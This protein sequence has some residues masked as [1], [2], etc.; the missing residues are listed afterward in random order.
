[1]Q[2]MV[3]QALI[4]IVVGIISIFTYGQTN[5]F[6]MAFAL[7]VILA[8]AVAFFANKDD[9]AGL[10]QTEIKAAVQTKPASKQPTNEIDEFNML[11]MA[12]NLAFSF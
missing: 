12:E 11:D 1:M 3:K 4:T 7:L 6:M 5:S 8:G 10:Q 9:K 2:I